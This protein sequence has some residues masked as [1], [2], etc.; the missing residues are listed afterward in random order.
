MESPN[1]IENCIEKYIMHSQRKIV[2]YKISINSNIEDI[3]DKITK[4]IE[5]KYDVHLMGLNTAI[6]KVVLISEIIKSKIGGIHQLCTISSL[7]NEDNNYKYEIDKLMP[8]L[9]ILLSLDE[10]IFKGNGYQPPY[11]VNP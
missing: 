2:K 5:F 11:K 9:D 1:K 7:T 6:N 10:P 3:I 4:D 8:K